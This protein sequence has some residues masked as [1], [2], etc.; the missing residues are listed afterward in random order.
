VCV[1]VCVCV[2][3]FIYFICGIL[4]VIALCEWF[5]LT[6]IYISVQVHS[7]NGRHFAV[8]EVNGCSYTNMTF[9]GT[10]PWLRQLLTGLSP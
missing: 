5:H 9:P 1:C 6:I 8:S 10:V 7:Y 4:V 2:Y 3:I